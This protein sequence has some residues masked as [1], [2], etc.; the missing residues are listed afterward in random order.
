MKALVTGSAGFIGN[1]LTEK[2]LDNG[3]EVIGL[4]SF[5]NYY[6]K[7]FKL[8]RIKD[9]LAHKR[10]EFING[11]I[12][13]PQLIKQIFTQNK[14]E[15]V[16]HLAAQ[17]GVRLPLKESSVYFESNVQGFTNVIQGAI[18]TGV[19]KFL[20]ASSSSVY[21]DEAEIPYTESETNLNPNSIYGVTK[22]A[23]EKIAHV[24][25]R[26]NG[27][28][29]RGL[30]FFT[31]YGPWG[32]PDMAYFKIIASALTG[33]KFNLNGDGSV[34]RDF[35]YIDDI[36]NSI[37]LLEKDLNHRSFGF[38]DVVNI[39]G[40]NPIPISYLINKIE[41]LTNKKIS[42][43]QLPANPSD[44]LETCANFS[45]LYSLTNQKPN[46][47]FDDGIM[48]TISWATSSEIR[49]QLL[50]WAESVR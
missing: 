11:D 32:R 41:S 33:T 3:Y 18:E 45:Y 22:L 17:A 31:V 50:F 37:L 42:V 6:N 39:G 1:A 10:Y 2:L 13:H 44:V 47:L 34:K 7:D 30:R 12:C 40:G 5:S 23:N 21:G 36:V 26:T 27:M 16:F 25:S 8:L 46:I 19:S 9:N 48:R 49:S 24:L 15:V 28:K 4:D 35:T 20:Y 43:N 29:S 38:N 14:F